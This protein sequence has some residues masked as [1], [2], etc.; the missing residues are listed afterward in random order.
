MGSSVGAIGVLAALGLLAG[1]QW[2]PNTATKGPE[3]TRADLASAGAAV[4][5]TELVQ[6]P[7]YPA[8]V[9]IP[10]HAVHVKQPSKP[11]LVP[12]P[13]VVPVAHEYLPCASLTRGA[14][15]QCVLG[16]G[17]VLALLS[18][19]LDAVCCS[20]WSKAFA[21]SGIADFVSSSS[22]RLPTWPYISPDEVTIKEFLRSVPQIDLFSDYR[23]QTRSMIA[24]T[25]KEISD[26]TKSDPDA[27]VR[28]LTKENADLPG[29]P[30]LVGND[31][32]LTSEK[33]GALARTAGEIR[34]VLEQAMGLRQIGA[35]PG[36]RPSF[37]STYPTKATSSEEAAANFT[38]VQAQHIPALRQILLAEER[39]IRLAAVK[40]LQ[41][42]PDPQATAVL[43]GCAIF[44]IDAEVREQAL[45]ALLDRPT[46][47]LE[48]AVA[49][50]LRYPW[51]PA[52]Y[53]AT[54]VVATLRMH[55]F[56]P[57]L[58]AMLD[59]PDPDAPFAN[60]WRSTIIVTAC[61]AMRL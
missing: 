56:I 14:S 12:A 52:V 32:A 49:A 26:Q 8:K 19:G 31:C 45:H 48:D 23:A 13:V 46:A 47:G 36:S 41:T 15:Y 27:F 20:S 6:L 54:R 40:V 17:L 42:I 34:S 2:I 43:A 21:C 22:P 60:W 24:F 50:A 37:A 28:R 16:T 11:G 61:C 3:P 29:F 59:A 5:T 57:D 18:S 30:F 51:R 35:R 44:D 9:A 53:N 55:Q 4:A 58:V 39:M 1:L 25:A 38:G 10:A 33:A 7:D